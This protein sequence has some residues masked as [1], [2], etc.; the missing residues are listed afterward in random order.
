MGQRS[1]GLLVRK[2][3]AATLL[4]GAGIAHAG[5]FDVTVDSSPLFNTPAVLVFDFFDGGPPDNTVDLS[6]LTSDGTQGATTVIPPGSITG[7]GPWHFPDA[8]SPELQVSFTKLGTFV[9]FSFVTSDNPADPS[10]GSSPD[11]F[12]FSIL[13]PDLSPLVTTDEPLG[14][15]ALFLYNIGEGQDGLAV[16]NPLLTPEQVGFSFAVAPAQSVPEPASLALLAVGLAALS[17][18]RR[19]MP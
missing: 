18:R 10:S 3:L 4:L 15:N 16:F 12:S 11:T 19:R 6:A 8:G 13:N 17:T 1:Y 9:T 7:A 14:S 2:G 5:A